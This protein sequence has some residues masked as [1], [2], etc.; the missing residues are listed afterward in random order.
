ME[1]VM[2]R[3]G[4]GL[5]IKPMSTF[6]ASVRG[7]QR[8]EEEAACV[9]KTSEE[10]RGGRGGSVK[11]FINSSQSHGAFFAHFYVMSCPYS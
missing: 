5:K 1:K 4:G 11:M 6:F 9:L 7:I 8:E 2:A 3:W 10:R